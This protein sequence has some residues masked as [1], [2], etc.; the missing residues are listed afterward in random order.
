[1]LSSSPRSILHALFFSSLYSTCS[2]LRLSQFYMPHPIIFSLYSTCS[3]LLSSH[4]I[5]H[6]LI[7]FLYYICSHRSSSSSLFSLFYICSQF[8]LSQFYMHSSSALPIVHDL[9]YILSSS[10]R[11]KGGVKKPRVYIVSSQCNITYKTIES[12]LIEN[13]WGETPPPSF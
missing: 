9:F 2:N 1:M 5:L 11:T 6:A 12:L 8:F 10:S 3:M 4:S 7:S 13:P